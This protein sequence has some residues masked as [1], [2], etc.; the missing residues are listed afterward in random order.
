MFL[1]VTW[2]TT[3]LGAICILIG[4]AASMIIRILFTFSIF[5]RWNDFIHPELV[6]VTL[7]VA[8]GGVV[9]IMASQYIRGKMMHE[10][11]AVGVCAVLTFGSVA[12]KLKSSL[13]DI[14]DN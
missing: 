3:S 13:F 9:A 2:A 14:K 1:I 7:R 4:N 6:S 12:G 5:N 10:L 11:G 8:M